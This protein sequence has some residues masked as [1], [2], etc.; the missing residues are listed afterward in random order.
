MKIYENQFCGFLQAQI[1]PAQWPQALKLFREYGVAWSYDVTN[2]LLHASEKCKIDQVLAALQKHYDE[3]VSFQHPDARGR[4]TDALGYDPT[5][6]L[7]K[8]K[9][10][11]EILGMKPATKGWPPEAQAFLDKF[12]ADGKATTTEEKIALISAYIMRNGSGPLNVSSATGP[13]N[14][15]QVLGA[16]EYEILERERLIVL[17]LC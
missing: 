15:E 16:H 5:E 8:N 2:V 6:S 17:H 10:L 1:P 14:R 9:I 3:H 4:V 13:V 12:Y 11:V 7:F